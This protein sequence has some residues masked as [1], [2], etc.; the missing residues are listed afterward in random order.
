MRAQQTSPPSSSSHSQP[1]STTSITIVASSAKT[2]APFQ[3]RDGA[4]PPSRRGGG[5]NAGSV[6][7]GGSGISSRSRAP[8]S[9]RSSATSTVAM[10][11]NSYAYLSDRVYDALYAKSA[12]L[13]RVQSEEEGQ[14]IEEATLKV[15]VHD[16]D[17]PG[18][19]FVI[20]M[21]F[22]FTWQSRCFTF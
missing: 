14:E 10:H 18:G 2:L 8:L 7:S 1:T 15:Q 22:S 4:M 20:G 21:V 11:A 3:E 17:R 13:G 6:R 16:D 5:G 9:A 12:W 19:S